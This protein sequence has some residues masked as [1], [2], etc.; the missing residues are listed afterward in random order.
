MSPAPERT[1]IH[2][3]L[4]KALKLPSGYLA[5]LADLQFCLRSTGVEARLNPGRLESSS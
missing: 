5:S 1:D 3:R 2:D 4:G